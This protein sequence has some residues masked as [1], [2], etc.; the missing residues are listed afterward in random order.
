MSCFKI[1]KKAA[2]V[3]L[4]LVTLLSVS[5]VTTV[6]AEET[7]SYGIITA[8]ALNVRQEPSTSA[9]IVSTLPNGTYVKVNW[10][11]PG[12]ANITYSTTIY[13]YVSLDY[14]TI[15]TGQMPSRAAS[16]SKGQA[17]VDYAK[18]FLGTPYVYGGSSPSG[19]DC[20]G[21]TSYVYRQFGVT[22]NRVTTGQMQNGI[23]VAKNELQPGDIVGFYSQPGGSYVGHVGI[24]VGNGMMIH[25]PHSGDVV[26]YDSIMTGSYADRYAAGRRIF[27]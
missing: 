22:L 25:S 8:S 21:F 2:A 19:F 6:N 3:I 5:L 14:I 7:S 16:Y 27:Y 18:Q 23:W 26:K 12:W 10:L 4:T 11:Q 13:G 9:P 1:G 24:Y 15:H 17:V 20:S